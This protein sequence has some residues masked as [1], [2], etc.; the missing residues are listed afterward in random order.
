MLKIKLEIV[1]PE[2]LW[3]KEEV[4]AV[5]LPG[6]SG[7]MEILP[8]HTTLLAELGSGVVCYQSGGQLKTLAV[9]GGVIEVN[10]DQVTV[11]ADSVTP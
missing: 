3:V 6:A 7:E 10:R 11:L 8:M 2:K 1:T 4:E 9:Q 5:T